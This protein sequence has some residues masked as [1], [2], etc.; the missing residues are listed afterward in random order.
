MQN[1]AN[2]KKIIAPGI[3][4]K[5]TQL[6]TVPQ[7]LRPG[8]VAYERHMF[9][10]FFNTSRDPSVSLEEMVD[11][12]IENTKTTNL[13]VADIFTKKKE[14]SL[15]IEFQKIISRKPRQNVS[16]LNCGRT[17]HRGTE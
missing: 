1:L 15:A 5:G 12:I 13:E 14:N 17:K 3:E 2:Q 9:C 16:L 6:R 11:L 4:I 7:F 8:N 10:P